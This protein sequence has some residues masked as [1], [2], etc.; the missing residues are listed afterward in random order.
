M[1]GMSEV[2]QLPRCKNQVMV[3][4]L[5][6]CCFSGRL[7]VCLSARGFKLLHTIFESLRWCRSWPTPL[8]SRST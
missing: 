5:S 2:T 7:I 3:D 8:Y 1:V 6:L 4:L